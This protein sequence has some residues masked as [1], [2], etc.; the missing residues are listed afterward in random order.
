[1]STPRTRHPQRLACPAPPAADAPSTS[2]AV[3]Q[4]AAVA[5][6]AAGSVAASHASQSPAKPVAGRIRNAER[7]RRTRARS[8]LRELT[9]TTQPVRN[10]QRPTPASARGAAG[11]GNAN[12]SATA[13]TAGLVSPHPPHRR[14][15]RHRVAHPPTGA[16]RGHAPPGPRNRRVPVYVG[17]ALVALIAVGLAATYLSRPARVTD[18]AAP[19]ASQ[20]QASPPAST[21]APRWPSRPTPTVVPPSSLPAGSSTQVPLPPS[22]PHRP[23]RLP[24]KPP[25]PRAGCDHRDEPGSVAVGQLWHRARRQPRF[26]GTRR[27]R[28]AVGSGR[29]TGDRADT[30]TEGAVGGRDCRRRRHRAN[31]RVA[32]AAAEGAGNRAGAF[33]R[34]AMGRRHVN[35]ARRGRRCAPYR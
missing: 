29:H 2:K 13:G 3:A 23:A 12:A 28:A 20:P 30:R 8:A 32:A 22:P 4:G 9:H 25:R 5:A 34:A 7:K 27:Q 16:Q 15:P 10:P 24:S 18:E 14:R 1:M 31:G 6:A 17:S 26:V 35:G 21:R 33:Q 11:S 19:A